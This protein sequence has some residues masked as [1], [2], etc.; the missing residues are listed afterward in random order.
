M[1]LAFAARTASVLVGLC[2]GFDT[3]AIPIVRIIICVGIIE[4]RWTGCVRIGPIVSL[5]SG[6][7]DNSFPPILF[8]E[9]DL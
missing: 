4:A 3:F 9:A 2:F 6:M 1:I 8:I 7:V 5:F